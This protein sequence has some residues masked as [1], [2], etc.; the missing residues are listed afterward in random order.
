[1]KSGM[2]TVLTFIAGMGCGYFL[3]KKMTDQT[4]E[5]IQSEVERVRKRLEEHY[6][7]IL[8]NNKVNVEVETGDK[9]PDTTDEKADEEARKA[10]KEGMNAW[11]NYAGADRDGD[12]ASTETYNVFDRSEEQLHK[13]AQALKPRVIP[14]EEFGVNEKYDQISL[15]YY[16]DGTVADSDDMPQTDAE[17]DQSVGQASL[18]HFGEYEDDAVHVVNDQMKA[19]YEILRDERPF[20]KVLDDNPTLREKIFSRR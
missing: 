7:G 8:R 18:N 6:M 16:S 1:M 19:Y 3:C 10:S 15:T 9:V 13:M 17:I 5:R 2:G 11:V 20:H 14:P 4:E 12:N